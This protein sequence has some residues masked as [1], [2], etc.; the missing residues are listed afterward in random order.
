MV[1]I[2]T[3]RDRNIGMAIRM[4]GVWV[5]TY[6]VWCMIGPGISVGHFLS[7]TNRGEKHAGYQCQK[8]K[9]ESFRFH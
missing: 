1:D 5:I 6:M 7:K 8:K 4:N 9:R 2:S 3:V